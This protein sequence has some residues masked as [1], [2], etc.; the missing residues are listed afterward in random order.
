MDPSSVVSEQNCTDEGRPENIRT[1]QAPVFPRA[2]THT[3]YTWAKIKFSQLAFYVNLHRAVIGPSA[4]LTGRWRPDIDLRRMLTGLLP[5]NRLL[6]F[7]ER[8]VNARSFKHFNKADMRATMDCK[9][10]AQ[11]SVIKFL[12]F[13]KVAESFSQACI[14]FN[15]QLLSLAP[16]SQ[17]VAPLLR[18]LFFFKNWKQRLAENKHETGSA[19]ISAGNRYLSTRSTCFAK[20][21]KKMANVYRRRWG[22]LWTRAVSRQHSSPWIG[23]ILC[24]KGAGGIAN[25]VDP[26]QTAL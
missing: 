6:Y 9:L 25:S 16:Y 22:I 15:W 17:Y 7:S 3:Y 8:S 13:S 21:I 20:T 4:T 10:K 24:P 14:S 23:E 26:D 19:L 11:K 12:H 5:M 18:L 1:L 2:A